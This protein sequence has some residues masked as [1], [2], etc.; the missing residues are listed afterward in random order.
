MTAPVQKSSGA[1]VAQTKRAT[2]GFALRLNL[3]AQTRATAPLP[4]AQAQQARF[5]RQGQIRANGA[6]AA[7]QHFNSNGET[8]MKIKAIPT[9]YAGTNFRSR[10][11]ARWAAYFDIIGVSWDY[12]PIDLGGWCPDFVLNIKAG[13][14][15]AEVKPVD[16]EKDDVYGLRLPKHPS[17]KKAEA[18]WRNVWVLKLGNGPCDDS[19]GI[20]NLMD[21]PKGKF[22][23][24]KWFEAFEELG[25]KNQRVLWRKAGNAVQW[26]AVK[27]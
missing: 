27:A 7:M 8:R 15:Y 9:T 14:I 24:A 19:F 6:S 23:E 5:D 2:G 18:H 20:G 1:A 10:L 22:P 3:A 4:V 16:L 25:A 12:E 21:E 26:K 13:N 17:F 11:E